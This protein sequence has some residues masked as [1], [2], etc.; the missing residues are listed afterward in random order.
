MKDRTSSSV[1][2]MDGK[3]TAGINEEVA[4]GSLTGGYTSDAGGST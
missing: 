2:L 3:G 1:F 4:D